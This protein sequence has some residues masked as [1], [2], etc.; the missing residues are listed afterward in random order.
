MKG[1]RAQDRARRRRVQLGEERDIKDQ[2]LER[3]DYTCRVCGKPA[4]SVHEIK[5]KGMGGSRSAVSLENSIAVCGD[6]TRGCH[7]KLQRY[8]I[9][10]YPA[11]AAV[12]GDFSIGQAVNAND[13][14]FFKEGVSKWTQAI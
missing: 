10:V 2:V 12:T 13:E 9:R 11:S 3:D 7:G 6:G 8:E 5:A 14:L 4:Q 1:Y